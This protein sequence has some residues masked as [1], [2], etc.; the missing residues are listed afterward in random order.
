MKYP[1]NDL[2]TVRSADLLEGALEDMKGKTVMYY[3]NKVYQLSIPGVASFGLAYGEIV[4]G[5]KKFDIKFTEV[6][7]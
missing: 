2:W 5:L 6:G 1:N 7:E 4:D 3:P